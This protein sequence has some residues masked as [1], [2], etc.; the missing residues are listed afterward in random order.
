MSII[1][2]IVFGFLL[3]VFLRQLPSHKLYVL[4]RDLQEAQSYF[5]SLVEEGVLTGTYAEEYRARLDKLQVQTSALENIMRGIWPFSPRDFY[6]IF[7]GV[8]QQ[9]YK[10]RDEV[11]I[12]RNNIWRTGCHEKLRLNTYK[13]MKTSAMSTVADVCP[14]GSSPSAATLPSYSP[15]LSSPPHQPGPRS[16]F[17]APP[18]SFNASLIA[19]VNTPHHP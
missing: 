18:C 6:H 1:L 17:L 7:D 10:L 19:S 8:T 13:M 2:W 9:C 4:T 11:E 16:T 15:Q 3:F 5:A 12:V 14:V